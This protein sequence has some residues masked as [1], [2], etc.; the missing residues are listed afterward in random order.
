[1]IF[2]ESFYGLKRE[3]CRLVHRLNATGLINPVSEMH[4]GFH[5]K[6]DPADYP[7]V[8]DFYELT[9]V[10]S[11]SIRT[12]V[13]GWTRALGPGALLLIR[14]NDVHSR[15]ALEESTYI[16]VA[17]P[18][19]VIMDMF[20]YLE[21]KEG[22]A[23]ILEAGQPPMAVLTYADTL[24][25]QARLERLN[26]LP[27]E[28]PRA[29]ST[30]LRLL[31]MNVVMQYIL[32]ALDPGPSMA[33]PHWLEALVSQIDDPE[34]LSW[35]L[36]DL[37]H[38]CGRTK[39]HLCRSFK[40]YFGVTPT[41]YLNAKRL[42]YAANLLL[43]SDQRVVDIAYAAGFQSMSRFHHAFKEAFGSPPLAYKQ[44]NRRPLEKP[45]PSTG[46]E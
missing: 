12:T 2:V 7:Q 14:P 26:L 44:K 36:A 22:R 43:H 27:V 41:A 30:E 8:H 5:Q 34:H 13:G 24:L 37:A 39:E 6:I 15:V 28:S 4:Y 46:K 17:F 16:N 11:G 25:L 29:V 32:P 45:A 40:K 19:R 9:L 10:T 3:G 31:M 20:T 23:R 21:N 33:C 42:N 18:A 35:E 38:C 1:M